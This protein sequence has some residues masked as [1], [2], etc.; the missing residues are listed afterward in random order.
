M[1]ILQPIFHHDIWGGNRLVGIYG[2]D[3]EGLAHLYS[4]RCKSKDSNI[5]L[6]GKHKGHPL[7]DIIGEYPL[8]IALVDAAAH[9]SIQVHPGGKLSKLESYYFMES[10]DSGYIYC[11]LNSPI[12]GEDVLSCVNKMQVKKGDYCTIKPG[13]VHALTAGSFVYEIEYGAG[14]TYRIYDYGRTDKA[15][16]MRPLHI[17]QAME[18]IDSSMQS[19]ATQFPKNTVKIEDAYETN[20]LTDVSSFT[21]SEHGFCCLTVISG[22][23]EVD[24][25][26]VR[27]G[28]TIMLEEGESIKNAGIAACIAAREVK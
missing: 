6:N 18:V 22:M 28:M 19:S 26:L 3:A 24:G 15:G 20:F 1:F 27:Q 25:V 2:K 14:S 11:G 4:V 16:K 13:T 9:L 23:A 5:V 10:P 21:N 17:E 12:T 8:S 7:Y